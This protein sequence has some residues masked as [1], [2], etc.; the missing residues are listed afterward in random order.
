MYSN[1]PSDT[2]TYTSSSSWSSSTDFPFIFDYSA[3]ILTIETSDFSH[4]GT[5]E[6]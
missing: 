5:Y 3:Q 1:T 6:L 4:V 2:G